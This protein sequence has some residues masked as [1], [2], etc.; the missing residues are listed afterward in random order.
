MEVAAV[1]TEHSVMHAISWPT[2]TQFTIM[3]TIS[4][5]GNVAHTHSCSPFTPLLLLMMIGLF[6][7]FP[8]PLF[9]TY[10]EMLFYT[11]T[12][13]SWCMLVRVSNDPRT[14]IYGW[15]MLCRQVNLLTYSEVCK[16]FEPLSILWES[17]KIKYNFFLKAKHF[18]WMLKKP[19]E[20]PQVSQN[21][22]FKE[23]ITT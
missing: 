7:S 18:I 13:C 12:L 16:G 23:N 4:R 9:P 17:G 22:I 10:T 3:L 2:S 19:F 5:C 11:E 20:L 15:S 14:L 6:R 8:A 1:Q 21:Y